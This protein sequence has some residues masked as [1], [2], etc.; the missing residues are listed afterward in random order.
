MFEWDETKNKFSKFLAIH[1]QTQ[2]IENEYLKN[3]YEK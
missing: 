3:I 2:T 1:G